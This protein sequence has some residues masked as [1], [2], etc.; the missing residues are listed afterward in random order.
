MDSIEIPAL[1]KR[2]DPSEQ[3]RFKVSGSIFDK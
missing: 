3:Y 2:N 1:D